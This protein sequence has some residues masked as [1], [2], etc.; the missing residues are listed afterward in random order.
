MSDGYGI[1][2]RVALAPRYADATL[3]YTGCDA[4]VAGDNKAFF[5][6]PFKCNVVYAA[7]TVTAT[8]ATDCVVAF[9]RRHTAG[10]DGSDRTDGTIAAITIPTTTAVG[11]MVYDK[12]AQGN[13]GKTA[14][15]LLVTAAS[16]R[17]GG[18]Y[19]NETTSLCEPHPYGELQ[20]GN[21][22]VVQIASGGTGKF[23]PILV[24]DML[25]EVMANLDDVL[26]TA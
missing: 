21:E 3:E 7:C 25:G 10:S 2:P 14:A 17:A 16:C 22:V 20:P 23:T 19:W 11:T 15:D 9:D 4:S 5:D 12:A 18:G 8:I 1:G 24:V 6:I 26:E 13:M